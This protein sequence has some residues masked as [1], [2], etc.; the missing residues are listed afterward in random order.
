M[1]DVYEVF[2]SCSKPSEENR[3]DNDP[4]L[5]LVEWDS[6]AAAFTYYVKYMNA[7]GTEHT[8]NSIPGLSAAIPCTNNKDDRPFTFPIITLRLQISLTSIPI[9]FLYAEGIHIYANYILKVHKLISCT[10]IKHT[11]IHQYIIRNRLLTILC[12][13]LCIPQYRN[14]TRPPYI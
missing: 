2:S 9:T 12:S 10:Y 6:V 14:L 7:D 1:K 5:L 8:T 4:N 11:S 13:W 3:M